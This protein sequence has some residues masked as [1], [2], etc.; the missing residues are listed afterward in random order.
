MKVALLGL[1][2]TTAPLEVR[3]R[4]A[5][6]AAS[7]PAALS[8][9]RQTFTAAEAVL[10]STC[11]RVELYAA[12]RD[13]D[14]GALVKFIA[15]YHAIESDALKS[16][17]Y[18]K[19][20]PAAIE[21]LFSVA[22]S[23]DSMV[24]GESQILGQVRDA[25]GLANSAGLTGPVLNPLFQRAIAVGKHVLRETPLGEGRLSIASVAVDHARRIFDHFDDKSV[26]CIGAGKMA[27]LVLQ[28]F[29]SLSPKQLLVCNRDWQKAVALANE[30]S[31]EAVAWE[32]MDDR[33]SSID[34]VI[35]STG[36]SEPILSADRFAAIHRQRRYSPVFLIDIALPRDIEPAVAEMGNVYL[37]N[38]DDL[39]QS[40]SQTL[41]GRTDAVSAA[42]DIVRS[43]VD[44][45]TRAHRARELGPAIDRLYR[46]YNAIADAELE[47]TLAK[48]SNITE[49]ERAHLRD[50]SRRLV[51]KLLH[52]P[53]SAIRSG[54]ASHVPAEQYQHVLEQLFHL[55]TEDD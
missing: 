25:Y 13:F 26:M 17:V 44:Q 27:R 1:N 51:N 16:H 12:G 7:L 39:Q 37:Y 5:F 22:S 33:L 49:A 23:L 40:V 48:L 3:E 30:F 34:I 4:V 6:S 45:Y 21:H 50:L 46:R 55:D 29:S 2:H 42:R 41:A 38:L 53:V 10:L 15:D 11:N 9:F 28:S 52:D 18:E 8:A 54:G 36:S 31:G 35:T 19:T 14:A 24:L 32:E 20:G 47:R 43:A